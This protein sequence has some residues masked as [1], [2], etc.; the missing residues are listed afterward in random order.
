MEHNQETSIEPIFSSSSE[1]GVEYENQFVVLDDAKHV[2]GVDANDRKNLIFEN[3]EDGSKNI[4]RWR[5]CFFDYITNLVYDRDTES[6][7]IG[8]KNGNL[9]KFKVNKANKTFQKVKNIGNL[10]IG[11]IRSSHRFLDFV[12]F[13]GDQGKIRVLDLS[14][15]KLLPW[16]QETS[17]GWICSLQVC[18]K[19]HE[20]I[21]LAVSGWN[22]NYSDD[23]TDLFDLS[24]L[25]LED[26]V[27]LRKLYSK[28]SKNQN[29][30]ILEQRSIIKS[31]EEKIQNMTKVFQKIN[32]KNIELQS[33]YNDL[34]EREDHLK[35]KNQEKERI[36]K[37]KADDIQ[38]LTKQRDS[39]EAK[40]D[41]I[42]SKYNLLKKKYNHLIKQNKKFI[43]EI[44]NINPQSGF[45][46]QKFFK[47]IHIL[48]HHKRKRINIDK[49]LFL[50]Q[51]HSFDETNS[52][53]SIQDWIKKLKKEI[54]DYN[55]LNISMYNVLYDKR[56]LENQTK[57]KSIR[58][59][60]LKNQVT[61]ICQVIGER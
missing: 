58:I 42:F 10:G 38:Y 27:S 26:P 35:K 40:Y 50:F 43:E 51:N 11:L 5:K 12:F 44:N 22:T 7:Y 19:S 55:Y 30:I 24:A 52:D 32:A 49:N 57:A 18:L 47:K 36:I 34:K 48:Y 53:I 54:N 28:Y 13:G 45:L 1:F 14:T 9:Q 2:M 37:S 15:D 29:Q 46:S 41:K 8:Y 3:L 33:E 59:D 61:T 39:Y 23:K 31:L 17:I 20:E 25:L 16:C 4:F 60:A 21:Y 6:L 56:K